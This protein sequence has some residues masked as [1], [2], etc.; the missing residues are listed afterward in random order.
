MFFTISAVFGCLT[1]IQVRMQGKAH[2]LAPV[3]RRH[4]PLGVPMAHPT[5]GRGIRR[6]SRFTWLAAVFVLTSPL[7][8]VAKP[9]CV[10]FVP[11]A[12]A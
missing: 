1:A 8:A 6:M 10:L 5:E 7:L 2:L 9:V 11:D 3:H 12:K 4:P